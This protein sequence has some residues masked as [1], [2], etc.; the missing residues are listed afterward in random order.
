MKIRGNKGQLHT[1]A[2]PNRREVLMG[3]ASLGVLGVMGQSLVPSA[4]YANTPNRGGKFTVALGHGATTDTLDPAANPGTGFHTTLGFAMNN[5]LVE[6]DQDG[7]AV[8]E[9]AE[10]WDSSSDAKVWTFAI[11]QGVEFHDG[12]TLT[13]QDVVNSINIHR[14]EG[15]QS[16]LKPLLVAIENIAIDGNNVVITLSGGN[17]DLPYLMADYRL[18]ILP[19]K[20]E[21]VEWENG[22]GCGAYKLVHFEPGVSTNLTRNTNY[23]KSDRGHF[24]DIE[25]LTIADLAARTNALVTGVV[26]AIDRADL[27]TVDMLGRSGDIEVIETNGGTHYTMP[28][29]AG[30]APFDNIDVRQALK[31]S[32]DRQVIVDTVLSGFGSVANDSPIPPSSIYFNEEL[33][34]KSYDPDKAK[35]HLKKA[36]LSDLSVEID[37]SDAAFS[38]AV[39][40]AVLYR[41]QAKASGID[42]KVNRQPADGYWSNVW[43]KK[44]WTA[45]YWG[46]AATPD[47]AFT[48]AFE[49]TAAWNEG[50]WKNERFDKLLVEARSELNE[51]RRKELYGEMQVL[52]SNEGSVLIPMF[53]SNVYAISTGIGHGQIEARWPLDTRRCCER[54]W[55]V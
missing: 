8:P 46:G 53:A 12:R 52:V 6:T 55:R 3:G 36:G 54:W 27:S 2:A 16:S 21:G 29:N 5:Y 13:P 11:R 9:I 34:Q 48:Q 31:Y 17:A 22:I 19:A 14:V 49:S 47:L 38:G 35:F 51:A 4:T 20:G 25:I 39:D 7:R 50:F 28:M 24:D 18:P 32:I 41:E 33:E 15:T 44:P 43:M 42:I 45:S 23:W 10:S 30:V 40:T 26:D 1:F 37:I